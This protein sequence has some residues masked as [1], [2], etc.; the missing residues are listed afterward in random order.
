L[1]VYRFALD[2]NL[3]ITHD[4]HSYRRIFCDRPVEEY[5]RIFTSHFG[6]NPDFRKIVSALA[7]H[8]GGLFRKQLVERAGLDAGGGLSE[9]LA[10]LEA[11]GFISSVVPFDKDDDTA[12]IR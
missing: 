6:R 2:K 10:D 7:G 5:D 3:P 8:P 9:H 12:W 11:A 4:S 1:T